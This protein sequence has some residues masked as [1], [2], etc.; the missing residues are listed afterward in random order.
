MNCT[1]QVSLIVSLGLLLTSVGCMRVAKQAYYEV[2]GA[3]AD[4]RPQSGFSNVR[5]ASPGTLEFA[6]ATTSMSAAIVPPAVL[7]AYDREAAAQAAEWAA[8]ADGSTTLRIATDFLYFQKKGLL[9][10]AQCMARVRCT[11]GAGEVFDGVVIVESGS[12]RE[13]DEGDLG[14]AAAEGVAKFIRERT[15]KSASSGD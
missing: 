4:V 5:L 10:K 7:R 2:R 8:E 6:P 12:F 11:S 13:G 3:Q 1:R 14:E 15:K 9:S